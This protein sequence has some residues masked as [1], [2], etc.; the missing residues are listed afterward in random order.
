MIYAEDYFGPF[1]AG[2][3]QRHKG[4]IIIY[5]HLKGQYDELFWCWYV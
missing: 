4:R 3:M 5:L 2:D 1:R